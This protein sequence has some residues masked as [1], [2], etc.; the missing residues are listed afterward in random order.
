MDGRN[1]DEADE[2]KFLRRYESS[3]ELE[4]GEYEAYFYAGEPFWKGNLNIQMDGLGDVYELL[5]EL[6]QNN[7]VV[8]FKDLEGELEDL[9]KDLSE[10]DEDLKD[11][12]DDGEDREGT[13]GYSSK[14]YR[15]Y[16]LEISTDDDSYSSSGCSY[17]ERNVIAKILEPDHDLYASVG[18]SL[19]QPV[20]V[21]VRAMGEYSSFNDLF[22]DHGWIVDAETREQVWGMT[23]H[24]TR[25][26]G[27]DEKNRAAI[28]DLSLRAGDYLLYYVTDDSHS[29][30]DW[31]AP[32]PYNPQAYGI[33]VE[34]E[35]ESDLKYVSVYRDKYS[36]SALISIV[37][38]G[39]DEYIQKPFEVKS[40][41]DVRVYAIGEF[42]YNDMFVDYGWITRVSDDEVIWEMTEH[43]TRHAGGASKN[44]LFDDVVHLDKGVY[45]LDYITDGSHSYT[46]WNASPPYDQKNYG[47]T[48]YAVGDGFDPG[49]IVELRELPTAKNVLVQLTRVGDD[50]DLEKVFVLDK[51]TKVR[52]Y[53]LGEGQ[54]NEMFDYGWI[55]DDATGQI[56][57]EMTYRKT[58]NA[59]GAD[60][61]RKVDNEIML[62]AGKYRVVY[63]SDGSHSFASW[64]APQPRD[65]YK[66]G[67]TVS[68]AEDR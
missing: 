23:R 60:K 27:G 28:Q 45:T 16:L 19:S 20:E 57:W 10:L 15:D 50:E 37:R 49:T 11:M 13:Y 39:D 38:V 59:G 6:L 2:S 12:E 66:W 52:I 7:V 26:A 29:F 24:N 31:N 33:V 17:P 67:I 14:I 32:P 46:D 9:E 18:F 35:N 25:P 42:G 61:N 65:P 34:A 68:R 5:I 58:R 21:Q 56:V 4:P 48:L 8:E 62:D 3:L 36:E 51:P 40:D 47:V 54:G 41:C 53:A 64:N 22:V 30:D 55:E 44:R 43:N 1:T 63:V